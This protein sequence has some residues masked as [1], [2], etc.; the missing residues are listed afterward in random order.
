MR[1]APETSSHPTWQSN[2]PFSNRAFFVR[3][4]TFH[5]RE[6]AANLAAHAGVVLAHRTRLEAPLMKIGRHAFHSG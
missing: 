6:A 2:R 5:G 3:H 1:E 4:L